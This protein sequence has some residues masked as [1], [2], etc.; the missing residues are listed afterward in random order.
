MSEPDNFPEAK[1]VEEVLITPQLKRRPAHARDDV[2]ENNTLTLLART[3]S[4]DPEQILQTLVGEVLKLCRADSSGVSILEA[5][6]KDAVFRWHAIAG[7]FSRN[8]YGTMPRKASPC[9]TVIMQ[10]QTL[11]FDRPARFYPELRKAEPPIYEALLA[12][13]RIGGKPVGTVWAVNHRAGQEFDAEDA[14]LL[15]SLSRFA[16]AGH[17]LLQ[18]SLTNQDLRA[19]RAAALNL[20][21]DAVESRRAAESLNRD[22][23]RE[24]IER[25]ATEKALR[26]SQ[27][28]LSNEAQ[29][30][31]KLYEASGR[32][33][34]APDMQTA[35]GVILD[36][37]IELLGAGFGNIQLYDPKSEELHIV[38]QRGFSE[39]FLRTFHTVS[40]D[41]PSSC[42]RSI[43]MGRRVIIED[44]ETDPEYAP[45]REIAAKEGYRAIQSTPIF[46][47]KGLLGVISNHFREPHRP[48]EAALRLL[49]L[50]AQQAISLIVRSRA[51]DALRQSEQTLRGVAN[52]VPD[53]LWISEPD[54]STS[55]CNERTLQYTGQTFEEFAGWGWTTVIHPDDLEGAVQRYREAIKTAGAFQQEHRIRNAMG[56]YRWFLVRSEPVCDAQG[57]LIRMYGAAA[58]IHDMRNAAEAVRASEARLQRVLEI[59]TVGVFFFDFSGRIL[60][61]NTAFRDLIGATTAEL[62]SGEITYHTLTPPD[63]KWRD[64]QTL[65]ELQD[66]GES[67]PSESEFL[68][69]DGSRIW[70]YRASKKLPDDTAVEFVLDITKRKRA[71]RELAA[72]MREQQALYEFV[73]RRNEIESLEELYEISLNTIVNGLGCDRGSILLFDEKNVMRFVAWRGLSDRYRKRADGHSPWTPETKDPQTITITDVEQADFKPGLKRA[74]KREG[75][76]ALA[77]VP[78]FDDG[79]LVGK[80]MTYY[81]VPHEFTEDEIRVGRA[82]A[83]QLAHAINRLQTEVALREANERFRLLVEAARG[84]AIFMVNPSNVITHWNK[85]A[86]RVFG[87]TAEE[88]IGKSG[89]LI[90]TPEDR[91]KQQEEKEIAIALRDGQAADRRWHIRKD[92]TRI[93]VDGVMHRIDDDA[94]GALRGF[95]K[96]A[97]DATADRRIHEE[98][99][100]RVQE[101]TAELTEANRRLRTEIDERSQLEQ[102]VIRV[103]EREIRRIGD[104]LHD[105]LCQELAATAFFLETQAKKLEKKN[106]GEASVFAQAAR[107]VNANVGL[108][109]D[110]ARGLHPVDLQS[111]G[112]VQALKDLAFRTS[113][114][115]IAC[116][117]ECPGT[118]RVADEAIALNLYRIAAEAVGNALKHARARN[119][120]LSLKRARSG[121]VLQVRDDG[122]GIAER[123]GHRGM[124]LDIMRHR[125][126]VLGA[127]LEV[128]SRTGRGT[129]VTCTLP[130]E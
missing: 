36:A 57:K 109:R 70:V 66:S 52:V 108:A 44:V 42:S 93:W 31:L 72:R 95:A 67:P 84:Y 56:E 58:D 50:Y 97:R 47:A 78:L 87:W 27:A 4:E 21:E 121:L 130:G 19:S 48:T 96:I 71:E 81:N 113:Q 92:R 46:E 43:R 88:A 41:N 29:R 122:D 2:R 1:T 114:Y 51:Q 53:L 13:F 125:A 40:R 45:Y 79:R 65:K 15:E 33:L 68:C 6:G 120:I 73:R 74:I 32:A 94:T 7:E 119:I 128:Q 54:G 105:S 126:N 25:E 82:V 101:R 30:M 106:A 20:M 26:Q 63:W 85:G 55:W 3:L 8:L 80:F 99:E 14:R 24:V 111:G 123:V 60:S 64:Q 83:D 28:L 37:S 10:D 102:K 5:G 49:D 11:L 76:R 107:Q 116:R 90:F 104:D 18:R 39:E 75:I 35:L 12:P 62:A 9:G 34:V 118:V 112:I 91:K 77:F 98:L 100:R 22:L 38:A 110:L 124:G 16:A 103:S 129:T 69:G 115:D 59:N 17:N 23:Q 117:C 89:E 61:A 86:E 127:K